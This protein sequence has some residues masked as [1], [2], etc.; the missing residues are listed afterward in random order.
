MTTKFKKISKQVRI[1]KDA[2]QNLAVIVNLIIKDLEEFGKDWV[3]RA[4]NN[5]GEIRNH[6]QNG[7]LRCYYKEIHKSP[8]AV[9]QEMSLLDVEIHCKRYIII[10]IL[11]YQSVKSTIL[12]IKAKTQVDVV[13]GLINCGASEGL[14]ITYLSTEGWSSI[15][16][17]EHF[18]LYLK[19]IEHH[20]LDKL[21]YRL[22][23]KNEKLRWE[24]FNQ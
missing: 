19:A 22:E 15:L 1:S 3:L 7:L 10:D 13:S 24:A 6:A 20:F 17:T 9:E 4:T 5:M 14:K 18:K 21:N 8:W 23:S 2:R 12:G 16:D 11:K